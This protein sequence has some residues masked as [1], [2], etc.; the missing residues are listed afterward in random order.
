M[1]DGAEAIADGRYQSDGTFHAEAIQAKCPSK[2]EAVGADGKPATM[3]PGEYTP[4]SQ[5][6]ALQATNEKYSGGYSAGYSSDYKGGYTSS[7]KK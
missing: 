3:A 4:P 6:G 1:Q 5:A 7:D 2:Y